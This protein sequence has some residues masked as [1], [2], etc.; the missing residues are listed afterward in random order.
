MDFEWTVNRYDRSNIILTKV[1]FSV[2]AFEGATGKRG[3]Y[4]G[5]VVLLPVT[6]ENIDA[7]VMPK[8]ATRDDILNWAKE[9][10]GVDGIAAAK[11]AAADNYATAPDAPTVTW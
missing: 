3:R 1:F 11:A 5:S 7:F 2:F 10:L 4:D 9:A 6:A 8:D